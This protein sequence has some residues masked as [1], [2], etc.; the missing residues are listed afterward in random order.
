[1]S[2][3]TA[4]HLEVVQ[5]WLGYTALTD[6]LGGPHVW[7]RATPPDFEFPDEP[8]RKYIT[9]GDKTELDVRVMGH[10]RTMTLTAHSWT[11]GYYDDAPVEELMALQEAALESAPIFL[12][13]YG[14]VILRNDGLRAVTSDPDLEYRH[15]I[16]RYRISTLQV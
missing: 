8:L 5:R 7:S 11:K 12:A 9:V 10:G 16:I 6:A 2:I 14:N 1:M 15:G 3:L 4:V 13:G